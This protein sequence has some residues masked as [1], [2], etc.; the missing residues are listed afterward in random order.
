MH[1]ESWIKTQPEWQ[2]LQDIGEYHGR[3]SWL[4]AQRFKLL[5]IERLIKRVELKYSDDQPRWPEGRPHGG[6]WKPKEAGS[7]GEEGNSGEGFVLAPD[8]MQ[9]EP[10]GGIPNDK[11]NWT[12]QQFMSAYCEGSIRAV[13]P[14][15]FLD[16]KIEDV[17]ALAKQGDAAANRCWKLLRQDRFRK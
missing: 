16:M 7:E 13:M 3:N 4:Q 12:T 8:G 5:L 10:I 1:R 14:G 9:I 15:Q 17:I 6:Q 11:L 2:A